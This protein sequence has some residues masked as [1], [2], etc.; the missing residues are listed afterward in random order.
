[1]KRLILLF[2]TAALMVA[3]ASVYAFPAWADPQTDS[4]ANCQAQFVTGFHGPGHQG[5]VFGQ[6]VSEDAQQ[7]AG[8]GVPYGH[9]FAQPFAQSRDCPNV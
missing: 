6:Q 7:F 2:M 4:N 3:M 5:N 1:V 9:F 8:S